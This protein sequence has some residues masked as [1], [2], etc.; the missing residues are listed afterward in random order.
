MFVYKVY[1]LM[2]PTEAKF[3]LDCLQSMEWKIGESAGH[4]HM[5]GTTKRNYEIP[6][7]HTKEGDDRISDLTADIKRHKELMRENFIARIMRP[8]FN[9]Y[10]V[11]YGEYKRHNDSPYMGAWPRG[12]R[13]DLSCTI[14]FSDPDSYEGGELNIEVGPDSVTQYKGKPGEAI[15]YSTAYPHWVSEVTKGERICAITWMQSQIADPTQRNILR[16]M[17]DSLVESAKLKNKLP[18]N[19]DEINHLMTTISCAF[20]NLFKLWAET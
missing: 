4:A 8:K 20:T 1:E 11:G 13:T 10:A 14:F 3:Y 16:V 19:K 15:V 12:N 7:G 18:D 6:T 2:S 5:T 17:Q 9:K